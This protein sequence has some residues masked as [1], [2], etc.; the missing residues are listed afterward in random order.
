M[1][2][3]GTE[4]RWQ[5]SVLAESALWSV[6]RRTQDACG[7]RGA[8]GG[9][10]CLL[11][12]RL[13]YPAAGSGVQVKA[14]PQPRSPSKG[15]EGV[16]PSLSSQLEPSTDTPASGLGC[17]SACGLHFSP[18][19]PPPPAR[20]WEAGRAVSASYSRRLCCTRLAWGPASHRGD[21]LF[22]MWVTSGHLISLGPQ[23]PRLEGGDGDSRFPVGPWVPAAPSQPRL[24][25]R[26]A[27]TLCSLTR[28]GRGRDTQARQAG[29]QMYIAGWGSDFWGEGCSGR[30]HSH[31]KASRC[32]R[33]SEEAVE[34]QQREQG[35]EGR[36]GAEQVHAGH[37][38]PWGQEG[39]ARWTCSRRL[40]RAKPAG[41]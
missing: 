32:W 27:V 36:I 10:F 31:A 33:N 29:A 24:L 20:I 1:G 40:S 2:A 26:R 35:S 19:W 30:G 39:V 23:W 15:Q 12:A 3:W 5:V 6:E 9:G 25:P 22:S 21:I 17:L 34:L 41:G 18:G 13:T 4:G 8:L 38:E 7:L 28:R 16:A 14:G 37:A 11:S